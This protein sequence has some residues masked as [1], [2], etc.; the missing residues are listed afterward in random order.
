MSPLEIAIL[1]VSITAILAVFGYELLRDPLIGSATLP[2]PMHFALRICLGT[3]LAILGVIGVLLPVMQGWVFFVLAALVLFPQSRFAVKA[4]EK[5]E[6]KVPRLV[7]WLRR[8]GV[9][10]RDDGDTMRAR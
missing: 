2:A 3:V 7:A 8:R 5:A 10:V 6:P 9:G 4:L 1:A